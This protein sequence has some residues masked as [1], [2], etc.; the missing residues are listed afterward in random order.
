[1][2][3]PSVVG[4]NIKFVCVAAPAAK[5]LNFEVGV[6]DSCCR[7]CC[8]AAKA[9]AGVLGMVKPECREVKFKLRDKI[10]SSKGGIR[11]WPKE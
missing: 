2:K 5:L 8:A 6:A 7:S 10:G 4:F 9:V 11:V 3:K 1:M